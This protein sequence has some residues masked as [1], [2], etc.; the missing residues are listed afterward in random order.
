MKIGHFL[1]YCL[2]FLIHGSVFPNDSIQVAAGER[3][4]ASIFHTVL[5]GKHYRDVWSTRIIVPILDLE[6]IPHNL[7]PVKSGGGQQTVSIHLEDSTGKRYVLRSLDKN[8]EKVLPLPLRYTLLRYLINDQ[9]SAANPYAGLVVSRLSAAVDIYHTNPTLF[10]TSHSHQLGEFSDKID[11]IAMLEEKPNSTWENT[12]EFGYPQKIVTTEKLVKKLL[13]DPQVHIDQKVFLKCRLFDFMINDWDRHAGQWVWLGFKVNEKTIYKPFPRDRD[14]AFFLFDD[15]L[16][17][18]LVSR[19][20]GKPKL[21]SFHPHYENIKGLSSNSYN[22]DRLFLNKLTVSDWNQVTRELMDQ[23][24]DSVII[25]ALKGW[26]KEIAKLAGRKTQH[27][28]IS[29]RNRLPE[30]AGAFY[31]LINKH[32]F[33][34]ATDGNDQIRIRRCRRHTEV[35]IYTEKDSI[36]LYSRRLDHSITRALTIYALDGEDHI[37]ISGNA[38]RGIRITVIGGSGIDSIADYSNVRGCV[39]KTL[40]VDS[41]HNEI[42]TG[43]EA[44]HKDKAYLRKNRFNRS[45]HRK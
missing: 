13:S 5:F 44:R 25:S 23:L 33:I 7:R 36:L 14:N 35:D 30:A 39:R 40:L 19:W 28:L 9:I 37:S 43:S 26:P 21:Q 45:G 41:G 11:G 17:P 24:N 22:M 2:L 34:A 16:I 29:R 6:K 42:H 15:G 20:W 38:K 32:V 18:F 1:L 10:Y 31:Y 27:T 8:P 12:R 4:K 3:Y